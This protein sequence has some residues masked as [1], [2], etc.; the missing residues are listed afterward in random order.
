VQHLIY[1][2]SRTPTFARGH[3]FFSEFYYITLEEP[4]V[5]QIVNKDL[6]V[7]INKALGVA[8]WEARLTYNQSVVSS[9]PTKGSPLFP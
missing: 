4:I 9:S 5:F 6:Q 8:H 1:L 3:L 7:T 2:L